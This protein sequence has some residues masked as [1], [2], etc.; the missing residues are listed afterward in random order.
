MIKITSTNDKYA[1]IKKIGDSLYL[2]SWDK[3]PLVTIE[4]DDNG[5]EI[6][7]MSNEV[8][9]WMQERVRFKPSL[10][11]IRNLIIGWYNEEVDNRILSGFKWNEFPVWLSTENQFNYKA[12]YDLAIQTNGANLPIVFKLGTTET[13]VYYTFNSVAEL[14]DFYLSAIKYVNDTLAEGWVKKD[15]IDWEQYKIE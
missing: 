6:E 15:S 1:P 4:N 8:S 2:I 10:E 7:V 5:D 3:K 9:T 11:Y 12:A 13:P 14:N